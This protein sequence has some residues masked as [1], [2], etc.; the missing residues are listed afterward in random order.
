MPGMD[1]TGPRGL[2]PMTGGG[3]GW[4]NPY[5]KG[6]EIMPF[7]RGFGMGGGFGR[8]FGFRGY[9]PPWPFVGRGRGGLPRGFAYGAP[10]YFPYGVGQMPFPPVLNRA[11]YPK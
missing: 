6:G 3:R 8:G 5:L 4:C 10:G 2:G 11:L 9:S 7:G 1:G